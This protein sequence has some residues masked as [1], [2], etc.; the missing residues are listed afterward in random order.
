MS[1]DATTSR[2]AGAPADRMALNQVTIPH[3]TFAQDVEASVA[4]GW[5]GLSVMEPK[6]PPGQ[7]QELADLLGERGLAT[8]VVMTQVPGFLWDPIFG[9]PRDPGERLQAMLAG[10]RRLAPFRP[11][12]LLVL[13]GGVDPDLP[14][15]GRSAIV[16]GL[17]A[18]GEAAGEL[19]MDVAL[20]PTANAPELTTVTTIA[21]AVEL[22]D[23]AD[24]KTLGLMVDISNINIW[25]DD[26][27]L[28]DIRQHGPRINAVQIAD[29]KA[30]PRSAMDRALP[31]EGIADYPAI[32]R[33]LDLAGFRGWFD[34]EVF[35]DD[36]TWGNAFPDSLL[37]MPEADM[38]R[39]A[40]DGFDAVWRTAGI[41]F[42]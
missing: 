30:E 10:L 42:H 32:L 6:V 15:G 35:S 17:R 39:R 3:S 4:A 19:G 28:A 27:L 37:L 34:L 31:G 18:I 41:D 24:I 7:E 21:G 13:T 14:D 25:G 20:E 2:P 9:G 36:G 11:A 38:L 33:A 26:G 5:G 29:R 8:A 12:T 1:N 23:E 40:L 22:I 16:S